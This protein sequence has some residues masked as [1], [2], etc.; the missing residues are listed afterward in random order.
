MTSIRNI[1]R[2]TGAI[3]RHQIIHCLDQRS[4]VGSTPNELKVVCVPGTQPPA[5][6]LHNWLSKHS[7]PKSAAYLNQVTGLC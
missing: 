1:N 7:S 2:S 5:Y 6:S 3:L 4:P